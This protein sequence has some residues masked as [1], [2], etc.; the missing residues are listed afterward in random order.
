MAY[1]YEFTFDRHSELSNETI[2][3]V[4]CY[5]SNLTDGRIVWNQWS[6]PNEMALYNLDPNVE[7]DEEIPLSLSSEPARAPAP[8]RG[9]PVRVNVQPGALTEIRQAIEASQPV[10]ADVMPRF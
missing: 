5:L 4:R 2:Q 10:W 9:E 3:N 7:E 6:I 8:S 1:R